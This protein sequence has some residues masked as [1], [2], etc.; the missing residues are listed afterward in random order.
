MGGKLHCNSCSFEEI[1]S[2]GLRMS[3]SVYTFVLSFDV[4]LFCRILEHFISLNVFTYSHFNRPLRI[5]YFRSI[6]LEQVAALYTIYMVNVL[7]S[8]NPAVPVYYRIP[9]TKQELDRTPSLMPRS[10]H[11]YQRRTSRIPKRIGLYTKHDV[12]L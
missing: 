4:N 5:I 11:V 12:N 7:F 3:K 10:Q 9:Y 1:Y 2:F 8:E 6:L